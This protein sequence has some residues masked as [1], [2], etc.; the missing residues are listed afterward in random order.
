M[1][2]NISKVYE[3]HAVEKRW[4]T[5]WQ[6]KGYFSA[7]SASDSSSFSIVIPPPNVTGSLHV[8][9][10][11]NN[12]L[13]DI[14]IRTKRM[15]GLNVLWMFGTD[16]AGIATQ[17]VVEKELAKEGS[18]RHQLGRESFIEK[19]WEW[20]KQSG[21]NILGQLKML[22][23][24]CDWE[25][26]RFTMD[27]GLS[28]AVREVFFRL[29][30]EGLIYRSNYIINW[31][32]RCHTALSD[33]E[34]EYHEHAGH[35]YYLK[36]PYAEGDGYVVVATTRPETLLGDTAVAV[37]PK[38][39]R[40]RNIAGKN[41][42]LPLLERKIPVLA[43]SYVDPE[44]GTGCLKIT[45]AHDPN[46]FEIGLRYSLEQVCVM[47]KNADMNENAIHFQG[48]SR[49]VCRKNIVQELQDR[50][51][52][53][54][55]EDYTHSV[56]HCYRCHTVI[57]PT[58]SKQWFVK[59]KD[60]AGPAIEV[61]R[62]GKI[63]FIPKQWENTYFDWMENIRDWCISRQIWWGH[64]IPVSYCDDCAHVIL[65]EDTIT[66]CPKCGSNS[67]TPETDVLDTWFSSAL[68]P[69]STMGWP[70]KTPL[71]KQYYPTSV[72]VTGF[73][74]IFF[75]VA[76]MIMMGLKFRQ[77]VPFKHVYIHA[78]VRD[79]H[80]HKMSKSK[81]NVIDPLVVMEKYG[82]DAVRF[83]L[84]AFAAQGRD[85]CLSEK[86][87]EGYRNF[88]N[89]IWNASRLILSNLEGYEPV[90]LDPDRLD[91]AGRW[92]LR[93]LAE[94][95]TDVNEA[96]EGYRFN[97]AA[98]VLYQFFWH[99]FCDWYLEIAK[100]SLY[101]EHKDAKRLTQAVLVKVMDV[102]M[103]LM[104]PIIPFITEEIWQ[105]LPVAGESIMVASWPE[106]EEMIGTPVD[107]IIM[108]RLQEIITGVRNIRGEMNIS[109]GTRLRSLILKPKSR[110]IESQLKPY[111]E[112]IIN[113]AKTDE[114]TIDLHAKKPDFTAL[115]LADGVE[116]FVNLDGVV[117]FEAERGRLQKG[118]QKIEK[119]LAG[120]TKKLSNDGFLSKAPQAIIDKEQQKKAEIEEKLEKL[121][122]SLSQLQALS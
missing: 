86:R 115:T 114:P 93:R 98:G 36:Y 40:F 2:E 5:F 89:K 7:P 75:W 55:I 10:A 103:R 106:Q 66:S 73:D 49:Q 6:E 58:I 62:E 13:Q 68:W 59:V 46:D 47:D 87:I 21:N 116:V 121:R 37:N 3:P 52:L 111:S 102:S 84:T 14:L 82:T 65:D 85:I 72:M 80:G 118:I 23:A 117:D 113:L 22:G 79:E 29:Y 38:D 76:R 11:L 39:E 35:L 120:V 88:I 30:K 26:E 45:P 16:H 32:P 12:A 4:Y 83:T 24:S 33:L 110:E 19:V 74:I 100:L 122:H 104:H 56:G 8:G 28:R 119:E 99:E 51:Y 109:P 42:I 67:L 27:E 9:H 63:R 90:T 53:E 101:G 105:K 61:V 17:N 69:F 97:E 91:L 31:C 70:D 96:L 78:L 92:I 107:D 25:R 43:D 44:F 57:E 1:I 71:L 18:S 81:G 77:E 108:K 41:V 64:R 112:I 15:Q 34:V 48:Q 95:V 20:K 94:L 54:K 50:H 60:L